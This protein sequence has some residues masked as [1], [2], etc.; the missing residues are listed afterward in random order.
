M[1]PSQ[2]EQDVAQKPYQPMMPAGATGQAMPSESQLVTFG[3]RMTY[4]FAYGKEVGSIHFDRAR[5]EIFY[6]GHN[7]R[8]MEME[9]WQWQVLEQL[10]Q[11]LAK[12]E[13]GQRF[14]ESYGHALD[15]IT[16]EKH[17][18]FPPK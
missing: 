17:Q 13:T 12:D 18:S 2:N 3:E 4:T 15:K 9:P 14:A 11:I 10:R 7:I 1:K 6:K 5:G 8:N 16:I